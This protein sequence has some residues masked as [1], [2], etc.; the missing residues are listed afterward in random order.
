MSS[1]GGGGFF[2]ILFL[3]YHLVRWVFRVMAREESSIGRPVRP[4]MPEVRTTGVLLGHP[5]EIRSDRDRESVLIHSRIVIDLKGKSPGMLKIAPP[6]WASRIARM[7]GPQDLL[8]GDR[9]FD[10]HFV[11]MANPESL[12]TR[13]FSPERRARLIASVRRLGR[14][15]APFIDL[16]KD[17][18]SV[19]VVHEMLSMTEYRELERTA[20]EFLEAILE[21]EAVA[22]IKWIDA[23]PETA[24]NCEVCGTE[25]KDRVVHCS[26]CKTPHHEECWQYTG[27]CSTYACQ[28]KTYVKDGRR[29]QS[30]EHRQKPD[31][32][33]REELVRDRRQTGGQVDEALRRFEQRQRERGR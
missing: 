26:R 27:E 8:I 24:G 16:T 20:L 21:T 31:D 1:R 11:I 14:T 17:S 29:V 2:L 23:T 4:R 28:E 33:L 12:A 15:W 30:R 10:Q 19:G 22:G 6:G 32:W 9:D 13:V 5:F 25:L 18:L 3:L 7:F